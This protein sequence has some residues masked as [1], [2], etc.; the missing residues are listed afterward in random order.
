VS[1]AETGRGGGKNIETHTNGVCFNVFSVENC[2]GK[3]W[4]TFWDNNIRVEYSKYDCF[5]AA[6]LVL[7]NIQTCE[8]H[9]SR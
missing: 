6:G 4:Y 3:N 1:A 7:L 5:Y 8:S 9:N 2:N